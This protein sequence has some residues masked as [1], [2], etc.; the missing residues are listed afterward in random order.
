MNRL[1]RVIGMAVVAIGVFVC[2]G[3]V[4]AQDPDAIFSGAV[5]SYQRG[6]FD[7]ATAGFLRLAQGGIDDVRVWYNLGNAHF[8]TGKIGAALAAYRRGLRL[9]PR[10]PDLNANYR[11]VRLFASDK[12][13]PAGQFFL[14]AWWTAL[15][16]RLS[17]IEARWMA[18]L[19]FWL[20]VGLTAWR[21]WP[22]L[23]PPRFLTTGLLAAVW[24]IWLL[25]TAA[26]ATCYRRDFAARSG[27][28]TAVQAD[29]RGGPGAGYALQFVAHDGLGGD[30]ERTESGW[31]LVSFPNGLKGWLNAGSFEAL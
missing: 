9:A 23:S 12:V 3:N 1:L 24:S 20:A 22:T 16:G 25:A 29:I 26:S 18:S 10:D 28:V 4:C 19:L 21:L 17:V 31:H 5:A 11:Y 2:P 30:I 27:F 7:S 6:Q 13:E 14:E 8:K 15:V